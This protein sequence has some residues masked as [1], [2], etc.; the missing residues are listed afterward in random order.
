VGYLP[1]LYYY[2]AAVFVNLYAHHYF[3]RRW[4]EVVLL[5]ADSVCLKLRVFQI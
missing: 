5:P 2:P 4:S 3:L 1:L